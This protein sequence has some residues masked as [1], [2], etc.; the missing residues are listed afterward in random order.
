MSAVIAYTTE[1]SLTLPLPRS[2]ISLVIYNT[3]KYKSMVINY[4]NG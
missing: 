3:V 4:S 1:E 2:S